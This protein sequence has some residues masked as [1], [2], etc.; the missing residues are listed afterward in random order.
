MKIILRSM[1]DFE[2]PPSLAQESPPSP[3]PSTMTGDLTRQPAEEPLAAAHLQAATQKAFTN[4]GSGRYH[5][6][7]GFCIGSQQAEKIMAQTKPSLVAKDMAQAIW[8]REVLSNR[9]YGGKLA[10]KD[11]KSPGATVRKQLSPEKV[12][13]IVD[14]VTHWGS[15]N[16][17]SGKATIDNMSTILSQKIPRCEEKPPNSWLAG[18]PAPALF[19]WSF[20]V[21]LA[22]EANCLLG[23]LLY[24][25]WTSL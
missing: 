8:G 13:L 25:L 22:T 2:V 15:Q 4:I 9:T 11:Y 5:V 1:L 6:T 18:L 17:T 21:L 12:A 23:T 19:E 24:W 16:N 7:N 10:P 3:I 14:A 20:G